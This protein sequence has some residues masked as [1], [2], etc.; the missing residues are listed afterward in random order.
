M[1]KG[2]RLLYCKECGRRR[3]HSKVVMADY[4]SKWTCSKGH[5]WISERFSVDTIDNVLKEQ[6]TPGLV[7]KL[8]NSD[9]A[10]YRELRKR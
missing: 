10:F 8:F 9:Y 5:S 2:L 4:R 3:F 6:I 1:N 7:E